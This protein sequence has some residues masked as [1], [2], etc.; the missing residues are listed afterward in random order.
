MPWSTRSARSRRRSNSRHQRR[1]DR[2]RHS[3]T[4]VSANRNFELITSRFRVQPCGLPR[5]DECIFRIYRYSYFAGG[6]AATPPVGARA[7]A[8]LVDFADLGFSVSVALLTKRSCM[9]LAAAS[10]T[11]TLALSV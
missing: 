2:T 11:G 3:G 10:A 6:A 7:S 1:D 5:N 9:G 4:R 8:V